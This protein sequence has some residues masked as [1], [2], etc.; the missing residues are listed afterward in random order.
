M[1]CIFCQWKNFSNQSLFGKDM[2]KCL[3]IHF[4]GSQSMWQTACWLM[5]LSNSA[6]NQ[7][8]NSNNIYTNTK[9]L[10]NSNYSQQKDLVLVNFTQQWAHFNLF[11]D[12]FHFVKRLSCFSQFLV[13]YQKFLNSRVFLR[14]LAD[15]KYHVL[16]WYPARSSNI[17]CHSWLKHHHKTQ[18]S[19][20]LGIAIPKS[21]D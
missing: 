15:K 4:C 19:S 18:Q 3:I 20:R 6:E 1:Q 8:L 13:H 16:N 21:W 9:Q 17:H 5:I 2:D 11:T 12:I 14:I 10:Q 7:L